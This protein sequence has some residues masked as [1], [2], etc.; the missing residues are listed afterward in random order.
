METKGDTVADLKRALARVGREIENLLRA[1]E[2]GAAPALLLDRLHERERERATLQTQLAA[3]ESASTIRPL[4]FKRMRRVLEDGLGRLSDVLA[5][6]HVAA[7]QALATILDGKVRFTPIDLGSDTRTYR[8]EAQLTLGR[9]RGAT[10]QNN[11]D[12]P[13]G[14]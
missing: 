6:D 7:R 1:I 8:F 2:T 4:D 9:I 5:S 13:D 12:V 14:I 3:S 11:G 10:R